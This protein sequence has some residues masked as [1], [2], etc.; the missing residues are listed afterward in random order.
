MVKKSTNRPS[1]KVL[2]TTIANAIATIV[3]TIIKYYTD[4]DINQQTITVLI[5]AITFIVG[6]F[7][8]DNE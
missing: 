4:Y 8:E 3:V 1:N 7:V 6:Y 2:A 5:T